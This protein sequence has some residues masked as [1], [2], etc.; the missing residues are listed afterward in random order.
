MASVSARALLGQCVARPDSH[1]VADALRMP[2]WT[3]AIAGSG[4]G[5][6]VNDAGAEAT[7]S[8]PSCLCLATQSHG[9]RVVIVADPGAGAGSNPRPR[10]GR[11]VRA[12]FPRIPFR[13][14][15]AGVLLKMG[16]YGFL[17]L[18]LPIMPDATRRFLP[19]ALGLA[20]VGVIYGAMVALVQKDWKKLVAYSSVSHLGFVML[21]I[22]SFTT[23]AVVGSVYQMLNHGISTGALFFM[24][25][26]LYD[27]RHTR[28]IAE[29][30]GI[31]AVMPWFSA[32]F[33]LV[34][35]SSIAVPGFNGFVG[36]FLILLG[37]WP[38]SP[39]LV[40]LASL[41]VILAAAYILWMVQRV[42]YGEVT[43]EKNRGLADLTAREAVVLVPLVALALFMGVA[44]PV[45][46]RKIEPSVIA[47]VSQVHQQ[48]ERPG[49]ASAALAAL[50]KV[51]SV[52]WA[53][54]SMRATV[55]SRASTA[56]GSISSTT[57]SSI[58]ASHGT[59]TSCASGP[60]TSGI[61][62]CRPVACASAPRPSLA[63]ASCSSS[64]SARI[65]ATRSSTSSVTPGSRPRRRSA[66]SP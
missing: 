25:G 17:R 59:S 57:A 65:D 26:M 37:A 35:L 22:A 44:S 20:V 29:F 1:R 43:N 5:G 42:L 62:P 28:D 64:T 6:C 46:T 30:G 2:G 21:G 33:L 8:S 45:F 27:R 56:S 10:G 24:V 60:R 12:V 48:I 66:P 41:G 52:A 19:W 58:F 54:S 31:K 11:R 7:F 53:S 36:E 32:L 63:R 9:R 18:S 51:V 34:C 23:T 16:S 50:R 61:D 3:S 4:L 47:L 14:L 40:V 55:G 13:V 39:A 38:F 49:V 15:L